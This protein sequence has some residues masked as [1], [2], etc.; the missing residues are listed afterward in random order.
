VKEFLQ[1]DFDIHEG[2][3]QIFDAQGRMIHGQGL[4]SG[5]NQ[6]DM[7]AYPEGTYLLRFVTDQGCG[8]YKVLK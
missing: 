8:W 7:S 4:F 5:T 3:M 2:R 6:V 1:I